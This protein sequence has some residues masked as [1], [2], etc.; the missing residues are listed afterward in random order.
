MTKALGIE[1]GDGLR[2]QGAERGDEPR[3]GERMRD[4][5]F[6]LA[7]ARSYSTVSLALLAGHPQL[8]GFPE[9]LLFSA[10]TVGE[11]L[12][13]AGRPDNAAWIQFGNM[14]VARAV[15]EVHEG[16]QS[17]AAVERAIDW[18]RAR[19]DWQ[20]VALM[21]HLLRLVYPRI[22]LE[23]SPETVSSK[24]ALSACL[25]AYPHSRY[26]H[27]TRH[28]VT[29]EQSMQK[30]Y[31]ATYNQKLPSQIRVRRYLM[32]W[33][34]SHLRITRSLEAL[35]GG[36]WMRVRAEDLLREP[37]TWL[38]RVLDWLSLAHDDQ[39][40]ERMMRTEQWAFAPHHDSL[41][42]GADPGFMGNPAL[43]PV[44]APPAEV[45]S[46]SWEITDDISRRIV[47]LARYLGY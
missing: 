33:Y 31:A 41:T 12:N 43:R 18:L 39:T 45:I 1:P 14:G 36:Q 37:C 9:M 10:P 20:T 16:C 40:I 35:P 23:K 29:T 46:P 8:Y 5:V 2:V 19:G 7:P 30:Y 21:N 38:P 3:P 27:L 42:G 13:G 34:S 15:A 26:L 25:R 22:G 44:A 47:R 6:L 17:R 32:A 28:P 24:D 4:P 11:L